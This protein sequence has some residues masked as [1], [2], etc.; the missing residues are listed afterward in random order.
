MAVPYLPRNEAEAG[1]EEYRTPFARLSSSWWR[2]RSTALSKQPFSAPPPAP[3]Q[4]PSY[5]RQA[6]RI[7][8]TIQV[9]A[10]RQVRQVGK[11]S[12][13]HMLFGVCLFA[14]PCLLCSRSSCSWMT[15]K[16]WG[17]REGK[18]ER[19]RERYICI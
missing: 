5:R 18:R 3:P 13:E 12:G 7:L 6:R 16:R 15:E 9:L 11:G 19:G 10:V 8:V 17:G 2:G 14:S 4:S 1:S